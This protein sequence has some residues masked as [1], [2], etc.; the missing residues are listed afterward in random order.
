[1][2]SCVNHFKLIVRFM[3]LNLVTGVT[4]KPLIEHITRRAAKR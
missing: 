1:L 3:L 2:L 4:M